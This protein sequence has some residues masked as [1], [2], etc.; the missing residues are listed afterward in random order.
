MDL[1]LTF[2]FQGWDIRYNL[3]RSAES[4][5]ASTKEPKSVVFVHGTPWS[6]VVFQPLIE[7]LLA[8][9]PYQ[10]L[11]YDLPGYGQS[12]KYRR[13]G[14]P[15][16]P[17]QV[18]TA[19]ATTT[20]YFPGDTSVKFQAEAL[21]ALLSSVHLHSSK[22]NA[23]AGNTPSL[24]AII[25]HDIAGAIVLRAHLLHGCDF[26]S[27]LLMDTNAVLPWGD[28]F[29]KLVRSEPQTFVQLPP[30]IFEAVVSAVVQSAC[31]NPGVLKSGWEDKLTAPWVDAGLESSS[32]EKGRGTGG[33]GE[34]QRSFVRQIAQANDG[35]VAE[36]LEGNMYEKVRCQVKVLWG[37]SDTWIPREKI[38]RL[39]EMLGDKVKEVAFI[40]EAGHLVML[41]QP[42]RVAVEVYD[43]LN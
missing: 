39:I 35:D 10:I 1:P 17:S 38:E 16:Q 30:K 28:G 8:K 2:H 32:G 22:G 4:D 21:A 25:A 9:G 26:A 42:G 31:F 29:Y 18:A 40:P 11:V 12:Q 27:M 20:T 7:T 19:T 13:P 24:P 15:T 37:E 33:E 6:S 43:W 36:M 23:N 14:D 34:R 5:R 3:L 41:D